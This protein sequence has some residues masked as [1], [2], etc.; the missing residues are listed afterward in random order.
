MRLIAEPSNKVSGEVLCPGDKSISQRI[1]MLGSLLDHDLRVE[2]FLSAADPISTMSALERVGF[3]YQHLHDLN[4]VNIL[5]SEKRVSNPGSS[6]NLGNSG[7]GLRLMLGFLGGLNI[8]AHYRGDNSLSA[9]P[10]ARILDPLN[11]MGIKYNSNAGK[12]PI[13]FINSSPNKTF[14][15]KLPVASAQVK[16]SILLAGLCSRVEI[17]IIEPTAT[18]DHTERMLEFLGAKIEVDDSV[19]GRR[20]KLSGQLDSEVTDYDVPGDFS[21]AAFL[22]I[23]ALIAKDADLLIRNVGIN[24]SRSGLLDVLL[25]MGADIQ[26]MNHQNIM[27]EPRA[28]IRVKSSELHGINIGGS[29]IANLIDEIPILCIA[30]SFASG[31]TKIEGAEELRVKE[32]DRLNAVARGL[33]RLEINFVEFDDGIIIDGGNDISIKN[34]KINSY[35]DHRIAMSFLI[36]SLRS[37]EAIR[38]DDCSNIETSF[39]SFMHVMNRIGLNIYEA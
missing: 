1:V 32:S 2:N 12:L 17:E 38:V 9:R 35:H 10:M 34:I 6:L 14:S 19:E 31:Q 25:E 4:T 39:P 16:S 20:I 7:T 8:K 22:I 3:K 26:L 18:R 23:S 33:E 5:N 28:D 21:S 30:A 24:Q 29:I 11:Q 37:T 13:N 36:A 15:Y 27:N